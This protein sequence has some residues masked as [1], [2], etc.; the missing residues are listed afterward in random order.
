M[1]QQL[2][3]RQEE[4][5]L[6]YL[7]ALDSHLADIVEGRA[8]EMKEVNEIAELLYIHPTHLSNTIKQATGRSACYFYEHKIIDIAKALILE[9]PAKSITAIARQLTY[10]PSNFTKFFKVYVNKTP[11]QYRKEHLEIAQV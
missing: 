2:K 9:H 1:A 11:G 5:T 4:I 10:D 7:S 3:S 8:T 6:A